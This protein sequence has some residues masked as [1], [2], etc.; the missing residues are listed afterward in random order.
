MSSREAAYKG[1]GLT[2]GWPMLLSVG[3]EVVR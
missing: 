2:L 1:D 3:G